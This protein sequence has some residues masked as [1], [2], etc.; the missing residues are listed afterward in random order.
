[1]KRH[2]Y[3][4]KHGFTLLEMLV[5]LSLMG[6]IGTIGITGFFRMTEYWNMLQENLRLHKSATQAFE[7][8]SKDIGNML[9]SKVAGVP[10]RGIHAD[11]E[12]SIH[13]WRITFEDDA[14][15]FPAQ[16][17]NPLTQ[18]MENQLI[19][20]AIARD[21]QRPRLVRTVAALE[22]SD[23]TSNTTVVAQ[24][25]AGMRIQYFDGTSW[26]PNWDQ[27]TAPKLV[28]ISLSLI[29]GNRTN[30]QLARAAT[31]AIQVQ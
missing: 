20:Y 15:T 6:V 21:D 25:A 22:Q 5:V 18:Q 17:I 31:F 3:R 9:S 16:H 26:Q 28:R 24:A 14:V 4:S 8:F 10:L 19:T 30:G 12:D 2:C 11:T 13:F 23:V 29:D 1:M 27:P 7:N